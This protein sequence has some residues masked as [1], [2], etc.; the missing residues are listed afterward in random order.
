MCTKIIIDNKYG[1]TF[2]RQCTKPEYKNGLC[3]H[4]FDCLENRLTK[5]EDRD[6]YRPAIQKDL[7]IG[8]SLKLKG[9][10]SNILYQCR[11]GEIKVWNKKQDKYI[12]CGISADPS[13]FCVL[14]FQHQP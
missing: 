6:T 7:E 13:L 3:K 9:T 5:W 1:M 11:K 14:D 2:K 8:R 4:H 12:P 10:N